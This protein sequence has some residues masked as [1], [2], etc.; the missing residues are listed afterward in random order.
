MELEEY[1]FF[2][3]CQFQEQLS[4]MIVIVFC[5]DLLLFSRKFCFLTIK[6]RFCYFLSTV[7]VK[8]FPIWASR[9]HLWTPSFLLQ[10]YFL[11]DQRLHK[12]EKRLVYPQLL[13]TAS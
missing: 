11:G 13:K 4:S 2:V 8:S 12:T 6:L 9:A 3:K 5:N 1:I 10:G 7:K